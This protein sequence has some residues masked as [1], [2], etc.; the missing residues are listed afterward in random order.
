MDRMLCVMD[1]MLCA[2]VCASH[3]QTREILSERFARRYGWSA[4]TVQTYFAKGTFLEMARLRT[5]ELK[6]AAI[7]AAFIETSLT[8]A[9]SGPARAFAWLAIFT[10][11]R[12]WNED[13]GDAI[14]TIYAMERAGCSRFKIRFEIVKT[15]FWVIAVT[16]R[17]LVAA[18]INLLPR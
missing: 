5:L 14:E 16:I 17:E 11:R 15:Y 12:I 13:V 8:K 10:P 6:S 3:K 4:A 7:A 18:L 2:L 9:E 1:R